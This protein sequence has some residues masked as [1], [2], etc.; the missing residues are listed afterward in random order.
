MD[1]KKKLNK[2]KIAMVLLSGGAYSAT[3]LF[4]AKQEFKDV[5]AMHFYSADPDG[6]DNCRTLCEMTETE[7]IEVEY[8]PE[9]KLGTMIMIASAVNSGLD[10][11]YLDYVLG[12]NPKKVPNHWPGFLEA[13]SATMGM[14]RGAGM[15]VNL[16][17]PFKMFDKMAVAKVAQE[18]N[19]LEIVKNLTMKT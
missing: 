10:A 9:G 1:S 16:H 17:A 14:Q 11:G 8:T 2:E 13:M 3:A 4:W 19:C 15:L 6:L 12:C 7:L 18:L 5:L